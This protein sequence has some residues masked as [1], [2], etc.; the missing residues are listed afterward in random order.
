MGSI[1]MVLASGTPLY[2]TPAL[3]AA[4]VRAAFQA[5]GSP[6]IGM[7]VATL[8]GAA[9]YLLARWRGW[10]LPERIEWTAMPVGRTARKANDRDE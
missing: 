9:V 1:P 3:V 5:A 6:G 8:V 7:P 4:G 2:A 10:T